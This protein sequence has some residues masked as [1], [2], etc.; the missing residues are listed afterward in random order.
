MRNLIACSPSLPPSPTASTP[1]T[2]GWRAS[3]PA[4]PTQARA[5]TGPM[6]ML[7]TTSATSAR[8]RIRAAQSAIAPGHAPG[9]MPQGG[10]TEGPRPRFRRLTPAEMQEKRQNGQCYFCPEPYTKDHKCAAKGVFLMDLADDEDDPLAEINDVEISLH[11]LTGL[12]AADAMLLQ[13]T[14]AGVQLRA[15]VDTGSTHTFIHSTLAQ[16]LGLTVT[17][18]A[19]LN[20]MVANGDRVRSPGVCLA[21][22]VTIGGEAFSIDCFAL[23]LGG[24]DLVLGV[25]W[26]RTLGPIVWD[27]A[28]HAM[29]FWYN[30]RSHHW[31]GVNNQGLAARAI[32]DP[33][34]GGTA[35]V[36]PRHLRGTPWS[37]TTTPPRPQDSPPAEHTTCGGAPVPLPAAPQG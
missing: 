10:R 7:A 3:S 11:A 14:V 9:A 16:R 32:A 25:R 23:D 17:P 20:V 1:M 29:S 31:T 28:A 8:R 24:F 30:G 19:G 13:V 5:P 37:A 6:I 2:G 4:R 36:V 15:L 26:L 12:N 35:T 34:T 18:R 21:T 33:R 27:F 22:P